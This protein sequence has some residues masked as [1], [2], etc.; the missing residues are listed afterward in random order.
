MWI[1]FSSI[2]ILMVLII[3]KLSY[4]IRQDRILHIQKI[5]SV[6][7]EIEKAENQNRKLYEKILI[8]EQFYSSFT[9]KTPLLQNEIFLLQKKFIEVISNQKNP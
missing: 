7:K 5:K 1:I 3:I 2:N 9:E 6:E 8:S 4:E